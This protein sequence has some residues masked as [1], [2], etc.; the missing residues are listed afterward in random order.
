M[1]PDDA[2]L[3]AELA[4]GL[5]D[6]TEREIALE[7]LF[8]EP[9][10]AREVA[11]WRRRAG[12]LSAAIDLADDDGARAVP[13]QSVFERAEFDI[14]GSSRPSTAGRWR[15]AL[16]GAMAGALAAS[17]AAVIVMPA[18]PANPARSTVQQPL[19][20]VLVPAAGE[21]RTPVAAVFDRQTRTVRLTATITVP[22]D[23]AA[24]LWRI[25]SDAVP[26]PLGV[27]DSGR[28]SVPVKATTVPLTDETIA[29]SIEPLGGSRTGKPTG[30][31][32]ASGALVSI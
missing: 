9:Q 32:I 28:R 20:A 1:T 16:G 2:A 12:A 6:G 25:G 5:L 10:F 4:L 7:R 8:V 15:W 24:E 22:A 19:V 13:S 31:V 27:I 21:Q 3:A 29:I 18:A 23:R 26:R 17:L 30:P 11:L 14:D